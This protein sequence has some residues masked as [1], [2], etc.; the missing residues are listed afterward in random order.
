[1]S[2]FKDTAGRTWSISINTEQIKRLRTR[3]GID[4]A[5]LFDNEAEIYRKILSDV[6]LLVDVLFVLCEAQAEKAGIT[7]SQFGE[8]LAGDCFDDAVKAFEDA[9]LFFCPRRQR[10]ILTQMRAKGDQ[11]GAETEKIAMRRIAETD[12]KKTAES[13]FSNVVTS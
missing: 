7:D 2:T 13:M 6:V 3:L 8:S 5:R 9:L 10:E 4:V 11:I 1:M 12:P